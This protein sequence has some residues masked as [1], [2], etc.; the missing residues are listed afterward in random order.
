M[1]NLK[2]SSWFKLDIDCI[3]DITSF[4][5]SSVNSWVVLVL[6]L[7]NINAINKITFKNNFLTINF[8]DGRIWKTKILSRSLDTD[9]TY[10]LDNSTLWSRSLTIEGIA[11]VTTATIKLY[12]EYELNEIEGIPL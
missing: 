3:G 6:R 4:N 5:N 11:P 10:N 12:A 9:V 7:H 1:A 8:V 2:D